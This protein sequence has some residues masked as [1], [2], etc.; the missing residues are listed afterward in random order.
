MTEAVQGGDEETVAGAL[1]TTEAP[2]QP[3][4]NPQD[5]PPPSAQERKAAAEAKAAADKAA[6]EAVE[7]EQTQKPGEEV[8]G[9]ETEGAGEDT[10]LDTKVWGDAGSDVANSVLETLQNSGVKP[11]EAKA[12]LWDAVQEGDPSKIDRDAL[13]EKVGKAKATLIM[14]GVNG[15]IRDNK[16]RLEAVQ[17][18]T[19]DVA[20]GEANWKTAAAWAVKHIPENDLEELR[21]MLDKGGRS[22]KVA[23]QEIVEK[24]NKDPKNT[25]LNKGKTITP[26]GKPSTKVENPL[27]RAQYGAELD[28]AHNR[29]AGPAEFAALKA[30]RDAG[31]KLGI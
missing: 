23:A 7:G 14:A 15:V 18:V 22:A 25:S 29:R 6:Q 3:E 19:F 21:G 31:K 17:K 28:R 11:D 16:E 10:P 24:Y 1:G 4:R 20:G 12:L 5:G 2:K 13:V 26:G 30:R 8:P 9:E 27:S